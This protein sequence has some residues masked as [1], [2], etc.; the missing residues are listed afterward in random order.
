M[1]C[2]I[3]TTADLTG[4]GSADNRPEG[5]M[6]SVKIMVQIKECETAGGQKELKTVILPDGR[7]YAI[8]KVLHSA[9]SY[10]KAYEGIRYTVII[11]SAEN[12]IY[13]GKDGWYVV[14][15]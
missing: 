14:T 6:I 13:K 12:Y 15:Q 1:F 5:V 7:Q 11:G 9:V 10:E 2:I 4:D 3:K 8:S